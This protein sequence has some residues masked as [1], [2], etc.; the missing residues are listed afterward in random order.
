[1]RRRGLS[2]RGRGR[3]EEV[4]CWPCGLA[5]HCWYA[6]YTGFGSLAGTLYLTALSA[7]AIRT[8]PYPKLSLGTVPPFGSA[9]LMIR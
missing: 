1:M 4:N 9:V 2:G 6:R 3:A 8:T 7:P 5:S